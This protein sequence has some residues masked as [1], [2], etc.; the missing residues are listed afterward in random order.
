[1]SIKNSGSCDEAYIYTSDKEIDFNKIIN[2]IKELAS[3]EGLGGVVI[4]VG[5]V[6]SPINDRRVDK[7]VYEVY[8]EYTLRRFWEIIDYVKSKYKIGCAKILHVKG[9]T[10]PGDI[11]VL[12]VTQSISRKE[13]FEAAKEIIDLVKHSTGIWKLEFREDGV[14]WVLGEGERIKRDDLVETRRT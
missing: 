1:M 7:L 3:R 2:E 4:Y 13:A 5:I 14:F 10:K 11:A 8:E 6:K 12:I 9:E